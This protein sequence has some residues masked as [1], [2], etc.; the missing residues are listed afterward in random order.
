M[1]RSMRDERRLKVDIARRYYLN[2][3]TQTEIAEALGLSRMAVQRILA[4]C[5]KEQIVEITIKDPICT[6]LALEDE[7]RSRFSLVDAIIVS[8]PVDSSLLQKSIAS[9]AARYLTE[10]VMP[11]MT[12]GAAW[13][14]T[15]FQMM[16]FLDP[17]PQPHMYPGLRVV[18]LMGSLSTSLVTH[19]Y[20]I[21]N[22]IGE[23]FNAEVYYISAPAVANSPNSRD[24]FLA[25][26]SVQDILDL[27]RKADIAVVGIGDVGEHATLLQTGYLTL[28]ELEE[29]AGRGAVGEILVWH[30]DI[31]GSLVESPLSSRI[32]GLSPVELRQIKK[33]IGVAGGPEKV[34]A[35]LGALRGRYVN[36]LVTDEKTARD[37]IDLD[38]HN[39]IDTH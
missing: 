21:V 6:C 10:Q 5:R 32:V 39:G 17:C 22:K 16:Q 26:R 15:V 13:G 4:Q 38:A 1:G 34:K 8:A 19:P 3:A 7:V 12:I 29:L 18:S 11:G 30:Y 25:E 24:I 9:F 31:N 20:S 23:V 14:R 2:G 33:V 37:L 35:I 36:V 28:Q 27:A